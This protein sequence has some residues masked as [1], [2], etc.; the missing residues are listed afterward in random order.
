MTFTYNS[1]N[2]IFGHL[3]YQFM[4]RNSKKIEFKLSVGYICYEIFYNEDN[5]YNVV[6]T[7]NIFGKSKTIKWNSLHEEEI[8]GLEK[9]LTTNLSV[10]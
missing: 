2:I 10:R 4:K 3:N 5:T 9:Y 6:R 7:L 8:S 1:I